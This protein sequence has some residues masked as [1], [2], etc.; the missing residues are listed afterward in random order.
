MEMAGRAVSVSDSYPA[1]ADSVPR[2]RGVLGAFAASA[3]L[4]GE[5]LEGV[6]LVVSEAV[7]NVVQHAYRGRPGEVHVDASAH[8]GELRIL[9][10]DDGC[11]LPNRRSTRG[12][13]LGLAWMAEFSDGLQL[14]ARAGG[15][16]EVRLR[17]ELPAGDAAQSQADLEVARIRS[18]VTR[19][20][21][22]GRLARAGS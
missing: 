15:G 2:A 20:R 21:G 19:R 6:R 9:I 1:V 18:T 14:L 12:L 13:G 22:I 17:F 4:Y 7:T 11:G 8:A 16:L 5:Q 10:A 3:G